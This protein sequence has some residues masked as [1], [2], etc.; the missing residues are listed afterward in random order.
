MMILKTRMDMKNIT[1]KLNGS[2]I[3]ALLL[4]LTVACAKDE[5]SQ[6]SLSRQFSPSKFTLT[7]GETQS[8]VTWSAS[9]FTIPGQVTYAVEISD[10]ADDFSTPAYTTTTSDVSIVLTDNELTIKK[11]YYARVKAVGQDKTGDS[12]WL[13][14]SSFRILGEQFL[15]PIT[16]DN[17]ID[18]SVRLTWR[19][20]SDLT[21]IIITPTTGAPIAIDLTAA[22]LAA[23]LKQVDNL[24]PGTIYTAEIFAG[25][26]TKG[27]QQF[28]TVAALTGNVI[29]LRGISVIA[30]P[31]ILTDTLP[32]I[33]SGSIVLLKRGSGYPLSAVYNLDRSVTIQSGLDF[34]TSLAIIKSSSNFNFPSAGGTVIDSLVFKDLII[35]GSRPANASYNSDYLLNASFSA[36]VGKIRLENCTVKILRGI[37]R[38]Q[39]GGAGTKY[40]SYIINNC[41]IDSIR[42]FGIATASSTSAF[43]NISI[44]NT[45]I[46]RTRKFIS[47]VVAGN[48]SITIANCT[49]NELVAGTVTPAANYFIDLNTANS[50]NGITIKNTIFGKVWNETG[51]G[52]AVAG[53]RVGTST[54]VNV[55]NSYYTSDF[56]NTTSP[57][58]SL[59]SYSGTAAALF[60]DPNNGNFKIL[61]SNFIGKGS[62]GD[63]R[64][65]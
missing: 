58:P 33:P 55:S 61:D 49:F 6:L 10:K 1:Y 27:T 25:S 47:H 62:S 48:S 3:V 54:A 18:K 43:A 2:K 56:V 29:D 7:N 46:Y 9:L 23:T 32:D 12:N 60:T 24:T 40:G 4:L 44:T 42:D 53:I 19:A 11:D 8:M 64:W 13:V 65:R 16:S 63:P 36:T 17:V 34:G 52:T 37:V 45:T 50:V 14:S 59:S 26:K 57:I 30:K 21:K 5:V 38:G 41:T 35:K 39:T 51:A 15:N 28:T 31:N 20:S 22:D